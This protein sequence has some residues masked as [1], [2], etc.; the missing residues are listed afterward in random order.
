MA[1]DEENQ[2]V[3]EIIRDFPWL[4]EPKDFEP[5]ELQKKRQVPTEQRLLFQPN[6]SWTD[7][8]TKAILDALPIS[9]KAQ[10]ERIP[11]SSLKLARSSSSVPVDPNIADLFDGVA[12]VLCHTCGRPLL[13]TRFLSHAKDCCK[14]EVG[15]DP[16]MNLIEAP[17]PLPVASVIH[18]GESRTHPVSKRSKRR[19]VTEEEDW[20]KELESLR[21]PYV[22][23]AKS[24][25]RRKFI[26]GEIAPKRRS[27]ERKALQLAAQAGVVSTGGGNEPLR[28][29]AKQIGPSSVWGEL[30][31][32]S[33]PV[34]VRR[35]PKRRKEDGV[36]TV[37]KLGK[38]R[39]PEV[40]APSLMGSLMFLKGCG[41]KELGG[42]LISFMDTPQAVAG[43][44][45]AVFHDQT[46][47][48]ELGSFE[49]DQK[50]ASKIKLPTSII[51]DLFMAT[52]SLKMQGMGTVSS[53]GGKKQKSGKAQRGGGGSSSARGSTP[54][55]GA[56][57]SSGT[58][59]GKGGSNSQDS[60]S[61][62][63]AATS[64]G[65]G[66]IS[67]TKHGVAGQVN[68]QKKGYRQLGATP[69]SLAAHRVSNASPLSSGTM[70]VG[71]HATTVKA[72]GRSGTKSRQQPTLIGNAA[73]GI[74]YAANVTKAATTP[75]P[76]QASSRSAD[77]MGL[78]RSPIS[79]T[80]VDPTVIANNMNQIKGRNRSMGLGGAPTQNQL[81]FQQVMAQ[82]TGQTP[83]APMPL[84]I[85]TSG[86]SALSQAMPNGHPLTDKVVNQMAH[87]TMRAIQ[88][89]ARGR[90]I[91]A[92][93]ARMNRIAHKSQPQHHLNRNASRKNERDLMQ[94]GSN[95]EAQLRNA[96]AMVSAEMSA[97]K[98]DKLASGFPII[99]GK[100]PDRS[101]LGINPNAVRPSQGFYSAAPN[102]VGSDPSAMLKAQQTQQANLAFLR[103]AHQNQLGN[104]AMGNPAALA[105]AAAGTPNLLQN[106]HDLRSLQNM[107]VMAAG[108]P[109]NPAAH[110]ANVLSFMQAAGLSNGQANAA[111]LSSPSMGP[112]ANAA[113]PPATMAPGGGMISGE[114]ILQQL[115]TA[116]APPSASAGNMT[117]AGH[118]GAAKKTMSG[119]SIGHPQNTQANPSAQNAAMAALDRA[120]GLSFDESDLMD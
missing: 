41:M 84:P 34:V 77:R 108:M 47:V 48:A 87:P 25:K 82:V 57:R 72:T 106:M 104:A 88:N 51:S 16:E 64:A 66:A 59:H 56:S 60:R 10:L 65:S 103:I 113:I 120:L 110:N 74:G 79:A 18:N 17:S 44:P 24:R 97:G 70:N 119:N 93:Q 36:I 26:V 100:A 114:A 35:G 91:M 9:Q 78:H 94:R 32:I 115:M 1:P 27:V 58:A 102:I 4:F 83:M 85:R 61:G 63:R 95:I 53:G 12:L 117:A 49:T 62:A 105:A 11:Q 31:R 52:K 21:E 6:S 5:V 118:M 37:P 112:V 109:G 22:P 20:E 28:T 96:E 80:V 2:S 23:R 50:Q 98:R 89:Q 68:I 73:A 8:S 67:S 14:C 92:A 76:S 40:P 90:Q 99:H 46:Y 111:A 101:A 29:L 43:R 107:G 19:L 13:R 3:P 69:S 54:R 42:S 71:A 45:G 15:T 86:R 81:D 7:S 116:T 39:V 55:K 30:M 75:S 33:L 38:V